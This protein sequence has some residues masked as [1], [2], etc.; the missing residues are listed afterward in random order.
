MTAN[1]APVPKNPSTAW[2]KGYAALPGV[3]DEMLAGRG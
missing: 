3:F 1:A 2:R